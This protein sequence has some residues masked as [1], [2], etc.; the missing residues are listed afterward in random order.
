MI[1]YGKQ[2]I[3]FSDV[4]AVSKVLKK[5]FLTQGPEVSKFEKKLKNYFGAKYCSVVSNGTAA[6]HLA[7]VALNWKPGDIILTSTLSFLASSNSILYAGAKPEFVDI[8]SKNYNIDIHQLEKKI[9]F[10]KKKSKK[11]VAIIATDF[12]GYPCDWGKLREI[13]LKYRL[14][15][16]ND[17][18]H[19]LGSKYKKNKSYAAKYA[20]IVTHSYHPVKN[21]TTGEGGAVLSNDKNIIKKI[22]TLRSHGVER[23]PKQMINNHGPWYYEMQ[24]L[25]FNYRLS[26][27]QCALGISQLKKIS[28]FIKKRNQIAKIYDDAFS[29]DRR[30]IIHKPEKNYYHSYHLYPLQIKFN[31][32]K[33]SKK[34]LFKK[35]YNNNIK[36]QVHYIPI[37]LQ[38]YYK[39]KFKFKNRDFP[40]AEKFYKNEVSLPIYYSLKKNEVYKIIKYIKKFCN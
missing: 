25:G 14:K 9:K 8:N 30:F 29:N 33:I 15:L 21:I 22:E 6:L 26:D 23:N 18:C 31:L 28:K 10:L 36:L 4:K 1:N 20:N 3:D 17:N 7:G 19:A 37:H 13:A 40:V 5:N 32:L 12:A 24:H 16:I 2:Y 27:I 11:V 35:M 38:P 39:K 34:D